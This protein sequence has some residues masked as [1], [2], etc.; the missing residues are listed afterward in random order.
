MKNAVFGKIIENVGKQRD[1]NLI[2]TEE[3]RT[4]LVS[5]LNFHTTEFF[6]KIC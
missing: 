6:M 4:C 2:I 5:E 3:R 1:I